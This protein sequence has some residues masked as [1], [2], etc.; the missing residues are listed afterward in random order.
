MGYTHYWKQAKKATHEEWAAF[1]TAA[2]AVVKA[3]REEVELEA[4][5]DADGIDVNGVGPESYENMVFG[6]G[7]KE[8][9][10]CKTAQRPYDVV[11]VA[12]LALAKRTLP[13]FSWSSDGGDEAMREGDAALEKFLGSK[14]PPKTEVDAGLVAEILSRSSITEALQ[15]IPFTGMGSGQGAKSVKLKDNAIVVNLGNG[16][17]FKLKVVPVK[18]KKASRT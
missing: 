2:K 7:P 17:G 3:A 13:G 14:A 9:A 5:I 10:F 16:M 4:D 15:T 6:H 12:L 18:F 11:V 1:A 8:F